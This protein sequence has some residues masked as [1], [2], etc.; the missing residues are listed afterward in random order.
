MEVGHRDRLEAVAVPSL[1]LVAV[2]EAHLIRAV[3]EVSA[4]FE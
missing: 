4:V 1:S 2:V 3:E